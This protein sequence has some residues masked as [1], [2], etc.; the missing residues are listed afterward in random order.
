MFESSLKFSQM[1]ERRIRRM[2][3]VREQ[4]RR[5]SNQLRQN[6]RSE[7]Q[8]YV[9]KYERRHRNRWEKERQ[10][11][12]LMLATQCS[13]ALAQT[14]SAH[15]AARR[16]T[17]SH[18][19]KAKEQENTWNNLDR[20][21]RDRG[22]SAMK[23]TRR[24]RKRY[25]RPKRE[26][27]RRQLSVLESS[28]M[29][30]KSAKRWAE[31][32]FERRRRREERR[33]QAEADWDKVEENP[34]VVEESGV[35]K[36]SS[37]RYHTMVSRKKSSKTVSS[38][39]KSAWD[40]EEEREKAKRREVKLREMEEA[41]E[42]RGKLAL[43]KQRLLLKSKGAEE[44]LKHLELIRRRQKM[45]EI[46]DVALAHVRKLAASS[47]RSR[48]ERTQKEDIMKN[49]G[50]NLFAALLE[51]KLRVESSNSNGV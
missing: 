9:E 29:N 46:G 12:I 7:K 32:D 15:D 49:E 13:A 24:L 50:T 39:R 5:I 10:E 25:E 2:K 43:R 23:T 8:D 34:K 26:A 47:P 38:G 35:S 28:E 18:V 21:A 16:V 20:T 22:R 14:G 33:Q 4:E 11:K 44:S 1:R 36:F 51:E 19:A 37:T 6:I 41:A 42:V 48:Q 45:K 17:R 27:R 40:T 30:R 31:T 3:Q